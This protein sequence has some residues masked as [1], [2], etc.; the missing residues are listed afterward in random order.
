MGSEFERGR[1]RKGSQATQDAPS[2]RG[3]DTDT[4]PLEFF[5]GVVTDALEDQ[6]VEASCASETYL[7]ALL[8]DHARRP[9]ALGEWTEPFGLRLAHA[10]DATGGERFEKLRTLGDD[11]LFLSGFFS[12][13]LERRGVPL[14]Y[15]AGLGRVAYGGVASML[16]SHA[17]SGPPVFDE[18]A[19]RFPVFVSVFQHVADSMSAHSARGDADV[20]ELYQRWSRTGSSVL[21]DALLRMGVLPTRKRVGVN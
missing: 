2:S 11:V 13:H 18:L 6:G 21:A 15:V 9:T 20:L 7:V 4:A 16:R 10:M 14:D 12:E 5:R 19:H 8:S 3:I 1:G 17:D